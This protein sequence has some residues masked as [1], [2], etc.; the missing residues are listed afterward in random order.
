MSPAFAEVG[1]AP[2]GTL[3][4][5]YALLVAARIWLPPVKVLPPA[6][7][8]FSA[9]AA[10]ARDVSV[11]S[12]PS[13]RVVSALIDALSVPSAASARV[14]SVVIDALRFD[15]SVVRFVTCVSVMLPVIVPAIGCVNVFVPVQLLFA[16]SRLLLLFV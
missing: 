6:R 15:R 8:A 14:V 7:L 5:E 12:A 2:E 16:P 10:S 9:S 11:D 13:A 4:D 3:M 1:T